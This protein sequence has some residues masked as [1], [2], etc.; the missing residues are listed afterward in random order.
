M[1]YNVMICSILALR[2]RDDPSTNENAYRQALGPHTSLDNLL[3]G[4]L[5]ST[6]KS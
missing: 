3:R 2:V 6:Q 5:V 1:V 4:R